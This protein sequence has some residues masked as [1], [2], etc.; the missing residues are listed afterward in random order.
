MVVL[1]SS[2]AAAAAGAA[3]TKLAEVASEVAVEGA[4]R[5]VERSV[6]A[7]EEAIGRELLPTREASFTGA[8]EFDRKVLNEKVIESIR[9]EISDYS[10]NDVRNRNGRVG[11]MLAR[12]SSELEGAK[13]FREQISY[14]E[15]RR[16]DYEMDRP[17]GSS[18]DELIPSERG[19]AR[20]ERRTVFRGEHILGEVKNHG[21]NGLKSELRIGGHGYEQLQDMLR[22]Q[23]DGGVVELRIPRDVAL[24]KDIQRFLVPIHEQGV[25][26]VLI[27]AREMQAGLRLIGHPMF[28]KVL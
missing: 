8:N 24:S 4:R 14:A 17:R 2:I 22:H 12:S 20:I 27:P 5:A 16:C 19:E 23:A 15:G 1:L 25:R 28:H 6:G 18:F 9:N 26:I 3:T 21:P 10:E 7:V 11:E 13:D